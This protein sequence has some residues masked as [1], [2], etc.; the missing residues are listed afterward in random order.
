MQLYDCFIERDIE[1]ISINP[2]VVTTKGK[3]V[4]T[5]PKIIVDDS[6]GFR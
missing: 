4:V 6:A 2:L 3:L 1:S 5:N